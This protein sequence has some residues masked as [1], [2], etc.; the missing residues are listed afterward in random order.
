MLLYVAFNRQGHIA[1]GSL[2]VEE[3]SAYCTVNHQAS[4]SNYQLSNMKHPARDSN[5]R[6]ERL[7][8]ITL[9]ATP[10]S[11][12]DFDR[13]CSLSSSDVNHASALS[14][15]SHVDACIQ[16]EVKYGALYGPF[17]NLDFKIH[18]CP[19]MTR[20]KQN[21]DNCHTIMYLS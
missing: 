16:E 17:Q 7:E 10:P 21:S 2:Q 15:E 9:T 18:V 11:L 13:N 1:T 20:E 19:L 4:A 8:A 6:P 5:Q 12:L 14:Y 3:T